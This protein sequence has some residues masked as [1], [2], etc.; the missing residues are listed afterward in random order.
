M[1]Y[2]YKWYRLIEDKSLE[3]GDIL[4]DFPILELEDY[5]ELVRNPEN[6]STYIN[7]YDVIVMTQSCDLVNDKISQI[8]LC[9]HLDVKQAAKVDP[10]FAKNNKLDEIRKGKYSHLAMLNKCDID[11]LPMGLRIVDF[12]L[13][14]VYQR[15]SWRNLHQN[16]C[17]V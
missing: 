3:Q 5:S 2:D 16:K 14:L 4:F 6:P 10:S 13:F 9:P 12:G 1:P 15:N 7:Q 11:E 17:H 8:V